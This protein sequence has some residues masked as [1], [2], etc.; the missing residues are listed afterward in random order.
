MLSFRCANC[1]CEYIE[2]ESARI[3]STQFN[4]IVICIYCYDVSLA[5]SLKQAQEDVT[6]RF[7]KRC[8]DRELED[9]AS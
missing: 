9:E 8:L 4:S 7:V 5:P 2:S 6:N 1:N 3:V